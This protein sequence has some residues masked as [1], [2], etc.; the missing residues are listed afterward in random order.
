M[1][2]LLATRNQD[3]ANEVRWI[4]REGIR[5]ESYQHSGGWE[6]VTLNDVCPDLKISED[7]ASYAENAQRKAR[8]AFGRTGMWTMGEDSGLEVDALNGGPGIMSA[9]FGGEEATDLERNRR[10][11]EMMIAVPESERTARFH[12]VVCLIDPQ[13]VEQIFEGVCKGRIAHTIR[14]VFGFGYDPVFIPE[15]YGL[16]FAEL[17][18]TVKNRISHRAKA[19]QKVQ[20]YMLSRLN[21]ECAD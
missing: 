8:A 5:P 17:G 20:A 11:L 1:K 4:F 16:T 15:G 9:R 18:Q 7:G 3:K 14:G 13:G 2:V 6:V 12:C 10:L 21:S 19:F